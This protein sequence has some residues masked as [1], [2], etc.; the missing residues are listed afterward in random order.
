MK[1]QPNEAI[2]ELR[3]IINKT[4]AEFAAMIGASKDTVVSWETG[5]NKLSPAFARRICRATGV[6]GRSLLLGISVPI[7]GDPNS[8]PKIYTA[9]D[10]ERYRKTEWGRSDEDGANQHLVRC[11][12]TLELLFKAAAKPGIGKIR[13]RLPG[14]LDSFILWCEQASKDFEL[15]PQIR[16]QLRKRKFK[17]GVTLTYREWRGMYKGDPKAL[18]AAG[19]KD[20]KADTDKLRLELVMAPGWAPG[21]NMKGQR[22]AVM[23]TVLGK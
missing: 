21:R 17:C 8:D 9:E 1:H 5:R 12:D 14:L 19:F 23:E 11:M 13:H 4:Q 3:R 22:P 2:R 15:G 20:D 7:T 16:E 6:D 10:F 18:T